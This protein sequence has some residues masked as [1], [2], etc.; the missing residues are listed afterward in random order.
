MFQRAATWPRSR[1]QHA[2]PFERAAVD[3]VVDAAAAAWTAQRV[4]LDQAIE[5]RD[6]SQQR[7]PVV[8]E[9][10]APCNEPGPRLLVRR[11]RRPVHHRETQL[12]VDLDNAAIWAERALDVEDLVA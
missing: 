5:V 9:Q 11:R 4:A 6:S 8:G 2:V 12:G 1:V 7:E 10:F 3:D